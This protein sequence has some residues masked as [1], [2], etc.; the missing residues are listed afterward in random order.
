MTIGPDGK[1][2]S[3]KAQRGHPLLRHA[4]VEAAKQ[5][6]FATSE[7][8]ERETEL[9]YVFLTSEKAREGVTP[10]LNPCRIHVFS[11]PDTIDI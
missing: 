10:Y 2:I 4:A 11:P 3:A 1:V 9:I 5:A 6:T 7:A 8:V